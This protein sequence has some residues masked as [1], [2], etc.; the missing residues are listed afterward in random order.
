LNKS[1][2]SKIVEF[3]VSDEDAEKYKAGDT[4]GLEVL[5]GENIKV[6]IE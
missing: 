5:E 6:S 1:D 3:P 2:F 4:L